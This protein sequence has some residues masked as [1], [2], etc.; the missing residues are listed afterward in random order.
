MRYKDY[1]SG[2]DTRYNVGLRNIPMM[3]S[4]V[5][6]TSVDTCVMHGCTKHGIAAG[7]VSAS[8][9][10]VHVISQ[11]VNSAVEDDGERSQ[12][13]GVAYRMSPSLHHNPPN[14]PCLC[15]WLY[16]IENHSRI[17]DVHLVSLLCRELPRAVVLSPPSEEWTQGV[18]VNSC[19]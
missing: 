14:S 10:V 11:Q 1:W 4:C 17:K 9:S 16:N 3:L 19:F 8:S 2:L 13:S 7:T 15:T 6:M 18:W 12:N 5:I